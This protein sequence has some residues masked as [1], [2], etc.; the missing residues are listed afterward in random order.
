MMNTKINY[1]YRDGSNYKQ[2]N[3]AIVAGEFKEEDLRYIE[4]VMN[5]EFFIPEQV[6][7]HL[8]RPDDDFTEDDHCW[9]ELDPEEDIVLTD[10]DPLPEGD[11]IITWEQLMDKFREVEKTGWNED[12]YTPN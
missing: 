3:Y 6:G 12:E 11:G 10:E 1:L 4:S 2:F 7:L 5:F 9:A 8:T